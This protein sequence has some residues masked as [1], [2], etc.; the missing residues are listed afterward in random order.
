MANF[1][2]AT[3]NVNSLR[4]RLPHVLAWL[5]ENQPDVLA[6]QEIKVPD[7]D[8]PHEALQEVGYHAVCSGQKTYNGVAVL[9]REKAADLVTSFPSDEDPQRRV[10][11][12]TIKNIRVLNLYVPNGESTQSSKYQYKLD[13]LK[14]LDLFLESELKQHSHLIV[15][16]DFNIAPESID[17][18]D[19]LQWE[20]SVLC[21]PPERASFQGLLNRGLKDC[22]RLHSPQEKLFSWWDYRLNAFKRNLG[23]RI[24]HILASN[25][26]STLCGKCYIDKTTR[27]WERPSD[28]APVVAEFSLSQ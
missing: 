21:S 16:G 3:W 9:T 22:F 19:P 20:G 5:A 26:L 4:V 2:I 13:W 23:L 17:V 14:K 12:A 27:G 8:F 18:H 11:G 24:D 1:K 15:L 25:A 28:H 6:L 7:E 10:L